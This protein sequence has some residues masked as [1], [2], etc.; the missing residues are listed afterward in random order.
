MLDGEHRGESIGKAQ[1]S[2]SSVELRQQ[3][4][5]LEAAESGRAQA[6]SVLKQYTERI[7][8]LNTVDRSI[9]TEQSPKVVAELVLNYVRRIIPCRRASVVEVDLKLGQ[10]TVLAAF[11]DGETALGEGKVV[12]L[13]QFSPAIEELKTGQVRVVRDS[14]NLPFATNAGEILYSEGIRSCIQLPLRFQDTLIGFLNLGSN[15]PAAFDDEQIKVARE[16]AST[17][18]VAIQNAQLYRAEQRQ[19]Q[20][21]ETLRQVAELLNA[22]LDVDEILQALVEVTAKALGADVCSIL[23]KTPNGRELVV[24]ASTEVPPDELRA[25]LY[26]PINGSIA[27]RSMRE[28]KPQPVLD[29]H[30]DPE[31]Y[32]HIAKEL[33][34]QLDSLLAVPLIRGDRVLGVI[35]A[36]YEGQHLFD[37]D[38]IDLLEAIANSASTA[39]ENAQLYAS[40]Q[41][42][43]AKRTLEL[44][45]IRQI[46]AAV[47]RTMTLDAILERGLRE[48]VKASPAEVG[49]IY[50]VE[51]DSGQARFVLKVTSDRLPVFAK[52]HSIMGLDRVLSL[53]DDAPKPPRGSLPDSFQIRP[54]HPFLKALGS[55]S[56]LALSLHV[57]EQLLGLVCLAAGSQD[58][59]SGPHE[60]FLRCIA[61][62]IAVAA[63]NAHLLDQARQDAQTKAT[64]LHEVSHRVKNNLSAIMGILA[65]E[66]NRPDE[67]Q[68]DFQAVMQ[69]VQSRIRGLATVH[70]LLS[71]THWAPLPLDRLVDSVVQA[72]LSGSPIR[73]HIQLEISVPDQELL[74]SPKQ[75]TSLAVVLNELTTNSIKHAFIQRTQGCIW[76]DITAEQQTGLMVT[77][78]FRDNGPGWPKDVLQGER[79]NVGMRLVRLTVRSPLRGYLALSNENGA[80]TTL[81]FR[82]APVD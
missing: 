73:H 22:S 41:A 13:D 67:E 21:S 20:R 5:R 6:E 33:G 1:N 30:D 52:E 46:A 37:P 16:V 59:F 47:N 8:I 42:M 51:T 71:A 39:L 72:A 64:L 18:A 11:A 62:Q 69:D 56:G 78:K 60:D 75:A 79:E 81:Q 14:R 66:M 80:V 40:T 53:M 43:L 32:P 19:R 68:A 55:N 27:G 35:E 10:A 3:L 31:Y 70:D 34:T 49:A 65:L 29:V 36:I 24:R 4:A 23:L 63:E 25:R 48:M 38:E 15:R 57:R 45:T 61:D 44:D 9:L 74:V 7:E 2:E 82:L 54:S 77:L 50:L 28:R 76:V 58:A 26:V 12:P 17:L